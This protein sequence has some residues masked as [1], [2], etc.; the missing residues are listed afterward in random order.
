MDTLSSAWS[1]VLTIKSALISLQGLLESPEPKDPQ[2][3][4]VAEMLLNRPGDFEH[5]AHEWAVRYAGAPQQD[6]SSG[7]GGATAE[8]VMRMANESKKTDKPSNPN[9]LVHPET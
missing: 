5:R 4:E 2:D 1:P 3:H 6:Q 7:S 9:V 8:D